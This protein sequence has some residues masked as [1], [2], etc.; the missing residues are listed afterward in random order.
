MLN[1]LALMTCLTGD[2][3]PT[4]LVPLE[5]AVLA[6]RDAI[7][8]AHL[9]VEVETLDRRSAPH[10]LRYRYETWYERDRQRTEVLPLDDATRTAPG[11]DPGTYLICHNCPERGKVVG[12][13][14]RGGKVTISP[15]GTWQG[16][17]GN[18]HNRRID[19]K[20]FGLVYARSF[21]HAN[22]D[23]AE[24][25]GLSRITG[26]R[27][28]EETLGG[29]RVVRHTAVPAPG[30]TS[31]M[32]IDPERG[33]SVVRVEYTG[34][35]PKPGGQD[36][37][38][39]MEVAPAQDPVTGVWYFSS[40]TMNSIFGDENDVRERATVK[41][42][43]L[44]R[45]IDPAVFTWA[46]LNIDAGTPVM[47]YADKNTV[48]FQGYWDG[49]REVGEKE[50]RKRPDYLAGLRHPL[51]PAPAGPVP[52]TGPSGWQYA[53]AAVLAVAGLYAVVRALR[54]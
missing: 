22:Y 6:A 21:T 47:R 41:A 23:A 49:K 19:I 31:S 4:P 7:R 51:P 16:A 29:R 27:Q 24:K 32:W 43:E 48:S 15:H 10:P 17:H 35:S 39:V 42:V 40:Y 45:G 8:D 18:D 52:T 26:F 36:F 14:R 37:R 34:P 1:L 30:R 46:G 11:R 54:R 12:L 5:R 28:S 3:G 25:V 9:V 50:Y 2:A 33:P 44:N 20:K 53:L 13:L 38:S